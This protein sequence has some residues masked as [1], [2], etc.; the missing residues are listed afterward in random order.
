MDRVAIPAAHSPS[1]PA[2]AGMPAGKQRRAN[3]RLL[4][5]QATSYEKSSYKSLH[6][7]IDYIDKLE[8]A[9][10]DFG[11]AQLNGDEEDVVSIMSIHIHATTVRTSDKRRFISR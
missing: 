6:R 8:K 10:A 4:L 1:S 2:I 11:E 3:L 7:F 5:E 9:E